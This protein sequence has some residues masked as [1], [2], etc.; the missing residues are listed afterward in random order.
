MTY[1]D[2][3]L[4]DLGQESSRTATLFVVNLILMILL[5]FL[6][7]GIFAITC[8][9]SYAYD[10]VEVLHE[11]KTIDSSILKHNMFQFLTLM[12]TILILIQIMINITLIVLDTI[13]EVY[14]Y[15]RE[16]MAGIWMLKGVFGLSLLLLTGMLAYFLQ[17]NEEVQPVA[18]TGFDDGEDEEANLVQKDIIQFKHIITCILCS[19][20]ALAMMIHGQS[21]LKDAEVVYMR[22][23][24]DKHKKE[25]PKFKR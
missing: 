19:L 2:L 3:D 16:N 10:E 24:Y 22:Y 6:L 5:L 7:I 25:L 12:P 14:F 23:L 15:I 4:L 13:D 17:Q 21:K 9:V 18:S 11:M 8:I 20:H 1:E